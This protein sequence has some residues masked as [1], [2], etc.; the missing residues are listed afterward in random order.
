MSSEDDH[1]LIAGRP[2]AMDY[3]TYLTLIE[4]N[5]NPELLPVLHKVLQDPELTSNIGWD[6]VQLLLPLLPAS[7]ECLQDIAR[8][9]NPRE[10]VLKVTEA[11]R[12]IDFGA[13]EQEEDDDEALA[14]AADNAIISDDESVAG[15]SSADH[16]TSSKDPL[17]IMQFDALLSMLSV[18]HPRIRT[19]YPSRFLSTSLQAVLS[20]YDEAG[21]YAGQ[22]TPA[23]TKFLKTLS[24][25]KRPHLP[26]R[27]SSFSV[28]GLNR[29][30]PAPDP[31]GSKELPAPAEDDLQKRL[32]QSFL[33]H[34]LEDYMSS[35]SSFDGV[36]A[37]SWSSRVHEKLHPERNIPN[38]KT[39]AERFN[40]E[41]PLVAR[42]G[43]VG[44]LA[45]LSVDLD[46]DTND[47]L[48]AIKDTNPEPTGLPTEE[49]PPA[50]A[51]DIPLAKTG[52]LFLFTARKIGEVIY[53][54]RTDAKDLPLFPDHA[55]VLH[56]FVGLE[57]AMDTGLHSDALVDSLL[58]L[59]ILAVERNEIGEPA[60]DEDFIKYLQ[61]TSL[62]AAN[63]PSPTLRYHAHYLTTTVLRSHPSDL[64]RLTFIR[65]TL[66][67]CPYENLKATAVGWMKGETIEANMA[68]L[69]AGQE[70][71]SA[72]SKTPGHSRTTSTATDGDESIFATPV[73]LATIAPFL[74]PE[75]T[76][77]LSG[78]SISEAWQKFKLD[79][80]LYLATLNFYYLLLSAKPLHTVLDVPGLHEGNDVGGSYLFPLRQAVGSF[81]KSLEGGELKSEEGDQGA[82]L[83]LG[84]LNVLEDVLERVENG[85]KTLNG[86]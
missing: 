22:L 71:A 59:G 24:G 41:E 51:A 44:Q 20:A 5:L 52:S 42:T 15:E 38:K 78:P 23:V 61:V 73:A 70:A 1:P 46:I 58:T 64:V 67:H 56:N 32:L 49:E 43:I 69:K 11:L 80:S 84:D 30:A 12:L 21:P 8:L 85:V 35:F 45:A 55:T 17:Q 2:P 77:D 54:L 79:L 57:T 74:F 83:G 68:T 60:E 47:L 28:A 86:V 40:T 81:R 53:G 10:V 13:I 4:H 37:L 3:L 72:S 29:V 26:P 6:L 34:V 31:E 27:T 7:E 66:E 82:S 62:L 14:R 48:A 76:H 63:N 19:K 65:D 33:T 18:L 9:G 36:P 50:A 75:I 16:A 25:T 39:F